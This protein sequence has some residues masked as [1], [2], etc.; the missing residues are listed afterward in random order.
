MVPRDTLW[1]NIIVLVVNLKDWKWHTQ[2]LLNSP[3]WLLT[4]Y[5]YVSSNLFYTY[6]FIQPTYLLELD[7][8]YAYYL[9]YKVELP[10]SYSNALSFKVYNLN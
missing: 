4:N 7:F 10:F 5:T 9:L 8:P 6:I 1:E 2:T 3:R